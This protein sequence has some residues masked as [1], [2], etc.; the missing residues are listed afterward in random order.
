MQVYMAG[1]APTYSVGWKK[2]SCMAIFLAGCDFNC[3]HCSKQDLSDFKEEYLTSIL[4]IKREVTNNSNNCDSI[5]F[6]GGEPCLQRQAILSISRHAKTAGM[7]IGLKTNGTKPDAIKSLINENL[8]DF[9]ELKLQTDFQP[10]NFENAT[11]SRN[12]FNPTQNIIDSIYE[13][14]SLLKKNEHKIDIAFK[15]EII[16]GINDDM[17]I[18]NS[19]A[20]KIKNIQASWIL[21]SHDIETSKIKTQTSNEYL[22]ELKIRLED[23]HP[24][25]IIE[26]L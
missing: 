23:K 12:F 1:I 9:V 6:T 8:I 17:N 2:N 11:K 10:E 16:Q 7:K 26:V 4:D 15:T 14:I 5:F 20:D 21:S 25:L 19:L 3:P 13:T 22:N 18:L 24:E